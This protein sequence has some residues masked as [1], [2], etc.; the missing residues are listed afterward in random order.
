MSYL[1][2][3]NLK[4]IDRY[5]FRYSHKMVVCLYLRLKDIENDQQEIDIIMP[6]ER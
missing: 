3:K 4:I 6:Q 2:K 5:N 1:K